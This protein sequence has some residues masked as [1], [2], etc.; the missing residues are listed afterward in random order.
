MSGTSFISTL[1]VPLVSKRF[2]LNKIMLF[3]QASKTGL[4]LILTVALYL[5]PRLSLLGVCVLMILITLLDGFEGPVTAAMIVHYTTDLIKANAISSVC[6]QTIDILGWVYGGVLFSILGLYRSLLI[7]IILFGI[8]TWMTSLLPR[9][10]FDEL[11]NETDRQTLLK[12]WK[13][14]LK[15]PILYTL[16]GIEFFEE[17]A[18]LIWVSTIIL[19]FVSERL[20]ESTR[21]W[22]YANMTYSV[23]ITLGGLLVFKISEKLLER[24]VYSMMTSLV[25]TASLILVIL[26]IPNSMIFLTCSVLIGIVSQL[27][28]IPEITILQENIPENQMVNIRS[29]FEIISVIRFGMLLLVMSFIT[30]KFGIT[31]SFLLATISL[32]IEAGLIFKYKKYFA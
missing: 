20:H 26:V 15:N 19:V 31:V 32:L 4:L 29:V 21:Y 6:F 16:V 30:Q 13:L 5:W 27:K 23:G 2:A 11:K 17:F 3:S 12:G 24:K 8:A 28:E 9:M 18:N 22:G 25:L 1:L 14:L 10:A 7:T